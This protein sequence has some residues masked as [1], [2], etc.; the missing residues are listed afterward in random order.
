VL[1]VDRVV[2]ATDSPSQKANN[3]R[4]DPHVA[5]VFDEYSE[6]WDDIRQIIVF[7]RALLIDSG[8]EFRRDRGLLYEK[9]AQY[10]A[11]APIEEG[12]AIV[13]EV[14]ADR[15]SAMGIE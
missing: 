15:V 9:Y 11:A 14:H 1:D 12:A 4:G 10:E 2:F 13:I 5:I 7:G 8:P 6:D 3:I